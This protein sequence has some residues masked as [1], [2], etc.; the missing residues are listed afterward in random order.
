MFQN[1]FKLASIHNHIVC[2]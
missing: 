2:L 1:I